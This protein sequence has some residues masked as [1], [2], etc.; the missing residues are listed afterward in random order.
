MCVLNAFNNGQEVITMMYVRYV[1]N[2][3]SGGKE[4]G[5]D[6]KLLSYK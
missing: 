4:Y 6:Y 5:N 1:V 2:G 3:D